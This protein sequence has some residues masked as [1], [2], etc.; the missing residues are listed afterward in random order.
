MARLTKCAQ[1]GE[2]VNLLAVSLFTPLRVPTIHEPIVKVENRS[3][4][5][6]Y[7]ILVQLGCS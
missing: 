2:M 5:W 4:N 3:E 6:W 7:E 1:W